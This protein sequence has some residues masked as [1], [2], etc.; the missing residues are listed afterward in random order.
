MN[1]KLCLSYFQENT[2]FEKA[3]K[4]KRTV[5]EL[6]F[7]VDA[8]CFSTDKKMKNTFMAM[9]ENINKKSNKTGIEGFTTA[10]V[11]PLQ[12]GN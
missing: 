8:C 6:A 9:V 12:F 5:I 10:T 1:Y 7:N 11:M 4:E 2:L 3:K